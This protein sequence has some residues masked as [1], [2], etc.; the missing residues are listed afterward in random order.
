[1]TLWLV[2]QCDISFIRYETSPTVW[3]Q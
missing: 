3:L 2:G 1:V